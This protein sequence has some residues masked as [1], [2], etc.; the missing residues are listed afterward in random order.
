MSHYLSDNEKSFSIVSRI[1][2]EVGFVF[3]LT[4]LS[5]SFREMRQNDKIPIYSIQNNCM[6]RELSFG[7]CC[8]SPWWGEV[9]V[10][11]VFVLSVSSLFFPEMRQNDNMPIYSIRNDCL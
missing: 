6:S 1:R 2:I 7:R 10:G 8:W 9:E 3:V 5:L 4:V 11:F